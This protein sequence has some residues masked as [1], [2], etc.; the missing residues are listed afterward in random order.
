MI[1]NYLHSV[2]LIH[3]ACHGFVD[4]CIAGIELNRDNIDHYLRNSLMLVTALNR[5]IGYDNAAIVA[6]TAHR[7]GKSLREVA[8][9]LGF[10]T[11][12]DFDRYVVPLDMTHA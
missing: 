6:K 10:V 7:E 9:A 4:Y 3:D 8:N 5:H 11:P 1:H 2:R 12:T